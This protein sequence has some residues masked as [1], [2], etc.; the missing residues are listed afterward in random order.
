QNTFEEF[1]LS[2]IE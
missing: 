2:D 1:P